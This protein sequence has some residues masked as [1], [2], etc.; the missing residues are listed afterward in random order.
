MPT[1]MYTPAQ[2]PKPVPPRP[3]TPP[4]PPPVSAAKAKRLWEQEQRR[5]QLEKEKAE[6]TK[7]VAA[8]QKQKQGKSKGQ[9]SGKSGDDAGSDDDSDDSNYDNVLQQQQQQR[10]RRRPS[11]HGAELINAAVAAAGPLDPHVLASAT[12][13]ALRASLALEA[14]LHRK[15]AG[16]DEHLPYHHVEPQLPSSYAGAMAVTKLAAALTPTTNT[17]V[18]TNN[19]KG[20]VTT[21]KNAIG[22]ASSSISN[23]S[24]GTVGTGA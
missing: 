3:P 19:I 11:L 21:N 1:A 7:A 24:V 8:A 15:E 20:V 4:P 18:K 13:A 5:K 10:R 16:T 2:R 17:N 9:G 23:S 12:D 14:G 6:A 22:T